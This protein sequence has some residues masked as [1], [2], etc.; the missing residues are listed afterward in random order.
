VS[1]EKVVAMTAKRSRFV[2][3]SVVRLALSN[4][5]W[6][7]VR[8]E[9]T[10]GEQRK[11]MAKT[12]ST[13]RADGRIEPNMEMIGKAEISAYIVDWSFVDAN[14]K[15]VPFSESAL[16]NLTPADYSEVDTVVRA[17]IAAVEDERKKA[18]SGSTQKSS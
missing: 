9:L 1:K 5:D 18:E 14:G 12:I 13:M 2:Q 8:R 16:D 15:S 6:L 11:A 10:V 7:D 17:H 3:P 4:D